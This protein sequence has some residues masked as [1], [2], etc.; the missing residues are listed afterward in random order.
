MI[1]DEI[2]VKRDYTRHFDVE[3]GDRVVDIGANA[4]LFAAYAVTRGCARVVCA[5]PFSANVRTI[6]S[7]VE[8][9]GLT[10]VTVEQAAITDQVGKTRL[11]VTS[12]DSGGNHVF[13]DGV[14]ESEDLSEEVATMTLSDLLERQAMTGVDFLKLDCEGSEGLILREVSDSLLSSIDRIAIEF[15]DNVS[16]LKHYEIVRRLRSVGSRTWMQVEGESE[17]GYIW[18]RRVGDSHL[19]TAAA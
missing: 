8:R 6:E 5:E 19:P 14:V 16:P 2:F 11:Y 13:P 1:F 17:F 3:T 12:Q 18:A 4:G 7:N 9:N 15:H 10:N